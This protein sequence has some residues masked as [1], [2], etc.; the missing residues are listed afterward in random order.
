MPR[1]RPGAQMDQVSAALER[2]L[3]LQKAVGA[4]NREPTR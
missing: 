4:T 1:C 3:A 2:L